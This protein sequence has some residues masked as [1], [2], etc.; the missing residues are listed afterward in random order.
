MLKTKDV[1]EK[2][3]SE[4]E[5]LDLF[6][7]VRAC[8]FNRINDVQFLKDFPGLK[9]PGCLIVFLGREDEMRGAAHD[10]TDRWSAVV[11]V[12]DAGGDGWG[13]AV[14]MV[15]KIQDKFLDRQIMAA[16]ALTIHGSSE[17]GVA[18]TSLRFS[19]Y[20]VSFVTRQAEAR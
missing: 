1:W 9:M 11:V 14:D 16:N 13:D 18:F 10:R 8:P 7:E 6:K 17:V 2:L 20:E 4:M 5:E 12:K 19:V 3:V 15:D